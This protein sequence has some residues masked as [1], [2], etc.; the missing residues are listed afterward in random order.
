MDSRYGTYLRYIYL[1]LYY[2][3]AEISGST[4]PMFMISVYE[5]VL[6]RRLAEISLISID[7]H[8]R[9]GTVSQKD[10]G[11]DPTVRQNAGS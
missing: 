11:R 5:M 9:A 1:P 4:G 3:T 8:Q 6:R 2:G 10:K 7:S